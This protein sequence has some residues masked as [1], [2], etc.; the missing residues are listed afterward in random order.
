MYVFDTREQTNAHI[1]AYFDRNDIPYRIGTVDT[2]DYMIESNP[3]LRIERKKNLA[4][5]CHNLCSPDRARFY[6][7]IR[8]AHDQGIQLVIL[9]EHGGDIRS[10]ADVPKWKNKYGKVSGRRL[11]DEIYKLEVGYNIPVIFCDKRSTG[12]KIVEIL[13][14]ENHG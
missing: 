13:T 12:R 4:E 8:R 9:C 11:Q 7:E 1:K 3:L 2:A 10:L 14:E 6:R 5:L